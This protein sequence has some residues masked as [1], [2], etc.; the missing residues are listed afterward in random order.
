[1]ALRGV[2]RFA[3]SA[4]G[5]LRCQPLFFWRFAVSAFGASRCLALCGV[6]LCFLFV[7]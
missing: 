3:V 4:F 1:M 7:A 5:A 6:S 2:W